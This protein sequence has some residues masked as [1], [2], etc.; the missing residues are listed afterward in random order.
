[1]KKVALNIVKAQNEAPLDCQSSAKVGPNL[2]WEVLLL[3]APSLN[4]V[5]L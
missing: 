5:F 1:V 2:A 4:I 3:A